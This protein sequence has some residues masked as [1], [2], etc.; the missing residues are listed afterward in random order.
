MVFLKSEILLTCNSYV[1]LDDRILAI[2]FTCGC[3]HLKVSRSAM[4]A[5]A[6]RIA[7]LCHAKNVPP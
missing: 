3:C 1:T 2:H 5:P 4:S 7:G 6:G